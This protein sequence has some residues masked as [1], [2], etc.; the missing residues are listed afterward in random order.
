MAGTASEFS[1]TSV[2]RCRDH[3]RILSGELMSIVTA[4]EW[5]DHMFNPWCGAEVYGWALRVLVGGPAGA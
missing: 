5:T 4:I 2:S 1:G 3:R